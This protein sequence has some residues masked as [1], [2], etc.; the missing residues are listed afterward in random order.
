M[1]DNAFS[2]RKKFI[3]KYVYREYS[4]YFLVLRSDR[5]HSLIFIRT[6]RI[7]LAVV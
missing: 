2:I 5:S 1:E 4:G 7:V 3:D 6:G